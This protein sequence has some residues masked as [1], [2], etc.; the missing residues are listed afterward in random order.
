MAKKEMYWTAYAKH[1]NKVVKKGRVTV[2]RVEDRIYITDS[3]TMACVCP[4]QYEEMRRVCGLLDPMPE[5]APGYQVDGANGY[6]KR[7][8]DMTGCVTF[9]TTAKE[10]TRQAARLPLIVDID[11]K[12]QARYYKAGADIISIDIKYSALLDAAGYPM[13]TSNTGAVSPIISAD[14]DGFGILALPIRL[15]PQLMPGEILA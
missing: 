13:R 6:S 4:W 2:Q 15:K 5:G 1:I 12:R 9:W 11:D 3:Y 7:E 8:T 10:Y 14:D